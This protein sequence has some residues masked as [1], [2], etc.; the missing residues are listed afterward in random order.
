MSLPRITHLQF[1][2][3]DI[4]TTGQEFGRQL[5]KQLAAN[6]VRKSGPGF[7]QLM[8]RMEDGWRVMGGSAFS[9]SF[10]SCSLRQTRSP[11]T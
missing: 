7:Y 10:M 8:A 9:F 4:L 1:L 3:L 5:R 2:V 6:G 11:R